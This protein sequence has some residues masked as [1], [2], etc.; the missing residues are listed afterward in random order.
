LNRPIVDIRNHWLYYGAM[1]KD[2]SPDFADKPL[3][4]PPQPYN[5]MGM[6]INTRTVDTRRDFLKW[7]G[8]AAAGVLAACTLPGSTPSGGRQTEQSGQTGQ[9]ATQIPPETNTS[10]PQSQ[11]EMPSVTPSQVPAKATEA[12]QSC[13]I[14][15]AAELFKNG[16]SQYEGVP[17]V[18]TENSISHIG[19]QTVDEIKQAIQDTVA[20]LPEGAGTVLIPELAN[21][22]KVTNAV[23][24][25]FR[26]GMSED[27]M[28]VAGIWKVE[29]V[30]FPTG[31][32]VL[33]VTGIDGLVRGI[34]PKGDTHLADRITDPKSSN[35]DVFTLPGQL[36]YGSLFLVKVGN[37]NYT[38][39]QADAQGN[40]VA[41]LNEASGDLTNI[42]SLWLD[43]NGQQIPTPIPTETATSA[44]SYPECATA[45]AT[46]DYPDNPAY[47]VDR[48]TFPKDITGATLPTGVEPE[49]IPANSGGTVAPT[50]WAVLGLTTDENG[51]KASQW[52]YYDINRKIHWYTPALLWPGYNLVYALSG[53]V[54]YDKYIQIVEA[55]LNNYTSPRL[56]RTAFLIHGGTDIFHQEAAVA[57]NKDQQ[58]SQS[59]LNA[60]MTGKN[61][62][63]DGQDGHRLWT[64]G[65]EI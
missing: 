32:W 40:T 57:I 27:D 17:L 10:T 44:Y 38:F 35:V 7:F 25:T 34:L 60:I 12:A 48:K 9:P 21:G 13:L 1:N 22:I 51:N 55:R 58:F 53:A 64:T 14:D 46:C 28:Q 36:S 15:S 65:G 56:I 39:A 50:S 52:G 6:K 4:V 43:K 41:V 54:T 23:I 8:T 24:R 47:E 59:V 31:G 18:T 29:A 61:F 63:E 26:L 5:E 33:K 19:A 49:T 30:G 2:R 3:G 37:C 42:A 62:P 20:V 11:T 16:I 45:Y